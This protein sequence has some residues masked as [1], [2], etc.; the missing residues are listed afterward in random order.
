MN[1]MTS[2]KMDFDNYTGFYNDSN[3]DLLFGEN[4]NNHLHYDEDET[5]NGDILQVAFFLIIFVVGTVGNLLVYYY[6]SLKKRQRGKGS[7]IPEHLISWLAI[8][9]FLSSVLNP[10]FQFIGSWEVSEVLCKIFGPLSIILNSTSILILFI[11]AFDR[12]QTIVFN[13][14]QYFTKASSNAALVIAILYSIIINSYLFREFKMI[15]GRSDSFDRS[16]HRCD[17]QPHRYQNSYNIPRIVSYVLGDVIIFIALLIINIFIVSRKRFYNFDDWKLGA[18]WQK[19]RKDSLKILRMV[20][21]MVIA[22]FVVILPKKIISMV[23][24]ASHLLGLTLKWTTT[25]DYVISYLEWLAAS[26]ACLNFPIYCYAHNSFRT[27]V[28]KLVCRK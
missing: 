14:L 5:L 20:N 25:V 19:R 18:L 7:I 9:D 17:I 24:L 12:E 4:N 15:G 2:S 28:R 8:I 3:E 26:K 13:K 16:K 27:F 6:F 21:F 22:Y 1:S 11:I 10:F 23:F